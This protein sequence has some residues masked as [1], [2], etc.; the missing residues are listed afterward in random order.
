MKNKI[1]ILGLLV[2][3]G[4]AS[5][6]PLKVGPPQDITVEITPERLTRGEYLATTVTHC[7][8]CHSKVDPE[9]YSYPSVPGTDGMGGFPFDEAFGIVYGSN[10]TPSALGNWTDGEIIQALTEGVNNKGA[11]LFPIMPYDRLSIMP[12]EEIYSLVAYIRSLKPISNKVG[13]KKLKFPLNYIERTFPKPWDPQPLPDS[14]DKVAYGKYLATIGSCIMCHT[15]INDK[16][17]PLEGMDLAGGQDFYL[18]GLVVRSSNITPDSLTGIGNHSKDNFI[19]VFKSFR[20]PIKLTDG[21]NNTVMPWVAFAG[22]TEEDLGAI[23]EYLRTV[24]P[25]KNRVEKY[26]GDEVSN[27]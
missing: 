24:K 5:L 22:M 4:C 1:M 7:T 6:I 16:M 9:Y 11:P 2:V 27:E 10:I 23:Y 25:V 12:E 17:E 14:S 19:S 15:P 26:P 3:M 18:P 8:A 21:T 13:K 20:E